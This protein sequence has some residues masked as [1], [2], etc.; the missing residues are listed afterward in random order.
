M[1]QTVFRYGFYASILIVALAAIN[2]FIVSKN[3]DYTIQE[4]AGYLAILL[5]MIFVFMGIRYYRDKINRGSLSF[6]EG[7][8][9]GLLITLVPAI[10]FS[11]FDLLY[12]EVLN[13]SWKD[14]YYNH[15]VQD[16]RTSLS[17]NDLEVEIKKLEE[18][19]EMYDKPLVLFLIM[20]LTVFVI[21]MIVSIISALSL[22]R[23]NTPIT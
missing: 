6:G 10:C 20:F 3:A 18:Q 12:T 15:Y 14:D 9:I 11:L 16:L 8:K 22:R 4:V 1:K 17:G 5:S 21:G 2:L 7:L 13:P 23:K 19:R